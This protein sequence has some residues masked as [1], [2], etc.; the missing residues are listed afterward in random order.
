MSPWLAHLY[1]ALGA[2][3]AL[4]AS[5]DVITGDFRGAFIW[6]G[7]QVLVDATDGMLARKLRVRERLPHFDGARIDDIIDYLCY[8]FVPA[9]LLLRAGLLPA[10][11]DIAVLSAI[12][13]SSAYGFGQTAAKVEVPDHF[14]TGFPSYWNI[15]AFYLFVL[16]WPPAANAAVL[17]MLAALVFVPMRFVYP[18]RTRA[19]SML[20]HALGVT[21]ALI[22]FWMLWRLPV[23]DVRWL[24][25]SFVFPVYYA[26]LSIWLDRTSP[27]PKADT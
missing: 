22:M 19:F 9:L 3:L 27:G 2:V 23:R 16:E 26:A 4:L 21:W 10:T 17:L 25:V 11:W 20:T 12:L 1:T 8:V 5:L 18:S 6:L 7:L 13:L 24:A 15:V 14:F